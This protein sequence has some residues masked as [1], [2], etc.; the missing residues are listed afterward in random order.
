MEFDN[1][2]RHEL[3]HVH[4]FYTNNYSEFPL[5]D[6]AIVASATLG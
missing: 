6:Q 5:D 2:H 4:L 1:T 3:L